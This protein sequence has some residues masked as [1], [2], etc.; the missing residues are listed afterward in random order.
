MKSR[1]STYSLTPK[2]ELL[3]YFYDSDLKILLMEGVE[4]LKW[5]DKIQKENTLVALL[6]HSKENIEVY[7]TTYRHRKEDFEDHA[8]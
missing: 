6:R 7:V 8:A 3:Q 4:S 2:G 1:Y 5:M